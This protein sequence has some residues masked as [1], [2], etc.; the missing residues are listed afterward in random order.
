MLKTN[1]L[2]EG[3]Y[4]ILRQIEKGGMSIVY[5]A[6]DSRLNKQWAI[7][8]LSKKSRPILV[9]S[10]IQEANLIKKFDHPAIPR[11]VDIIQLPDSICIVMDYIEGKSLD[12]ILEEYGIPSQEQVV[13]WALQI[14]DV[15]IYLH[16]QNPPVL[17]LDCKP[18]NIM[19]QPD[20]RIKIVDFGAAKEINHKCSISL[21]TKGYASIEQ[22]EGKILD[23]RSD[24]YSFGATLYH[25]LTG[26]NPIHGMV[27]IRQIH[28]NLSS[29][30]ENIILKCTQINPDKRYN[31]CEE[32][33]YVLE[34]YEKEENEYKREIRKNTIQFIFLSFLSISLCISAIFILYYDQQSIR[35]DYFH[36]ID[37]SKK[38]E[39]K[40]YL[41][42]A[43]QILPTHP[44]A[45][46]ALID[47]YKNTKFE[48]DQSNE[49]LSKLSSS[50]KI[51][52]EKD[53]KGY[54]FITY[55]IGKLYWYYYP[56]TNAYTMAASWFEESS[57][58]QKDETKQKICEMY[59]FIGNF[60]YEVNQMRNEGT[61]TTQMYKE[62]FY[63]MQDLFERIQ[64]SNSEQRIHLEL[65]SMIVNA[66]ESYIKDFVS[67]S[68]SKSELISL[69]DAAI[70]DVKTIQVDTQITIQLKE[71][72]LKKEKERR[73]Y[74]FENYKS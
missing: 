5:L 54:A 46:Q 26:K 43:I 40:E 35:N 56:Y 74:L 66:L 64:Q 21:G 14:L 36:L 51:F 15:L 19:L 49:F 69:Y 10:A 4:E 57:I 52:K 30:L 41:F 63:R 39:K 13:Q 6:I 3:K 8:E 67:A 28:S 29:G 73:D 34:H 20:G 11:I 68:I 42:Q 48:Q 47:Y 2:L 25:L 12:F 33:K 61:S 45:Y 72:I 23:C 31:S 62:Y 44:Q 22:C 59:V 38:E 58:L 55:E 70:Q 7:K 16:H 65:D 17:Y 24:I 37:Q 27:P 60:S 1:D 18:S 9:T 32:L 50:L 53:K 71:E